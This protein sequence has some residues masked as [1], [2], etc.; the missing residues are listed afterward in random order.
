MYIQVWAFHYM[1]VYVPTLKYWLLCMGWPTHAH[2]WEEIIIGA[3]V[4]TSINLGIYT[5]VLISQNLR[6]GGSQPQPRTPPPPPPNETLAWTV[7]S[8]FLFYRTCTHSCTLWS[9]LMERSGKLQNLPTLADRQ[10]QV[11]FRFCGPWGRHQE[12]YLPVP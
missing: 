11:C 8:F 2:A 7:M 12:R 1:C 9:C 6:G 4:T 3:S 10:W 5:D